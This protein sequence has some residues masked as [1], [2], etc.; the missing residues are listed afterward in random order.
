VKGICVDC[1]APAEDGHHPTGR[2][3]DLSYLDPW[4]KVGH[5]HDDHELVHDDLRSAGLEVA[6][7]GNSFLAELELGLRRVGLFLGRLPGVAVLGDLLV[8]LARWCASKAD[9][10]RLVITALDAG[11]PGWRLLPGMT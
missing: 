2:G 8:M 3:A 9:G 7:A 10:L 11:A 6:P 5:C 1:G 4:F